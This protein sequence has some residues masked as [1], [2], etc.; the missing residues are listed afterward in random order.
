MSYLISHQEKKIDSC[1]KI[2]GSKSESNRLLILKA[3]YKNIFIKNISNSE[4]T[5]ILEKNLKNL[6]NKINVNHAGTAMRFLTA[7]L[8]IQA[9]KNFEIYGSKRMHERPIKVLVDALNSI[10]AD[11]KY[12]EKDGFPPLII[13]G[14]KIQKDSISIPSNVSSQYISALLLIS[15]MLKNGLTIKLKE[16]IASRPYIDMT[17]FF[18]RNIGVKLISKQYEIKVT[19]TESIKDFEYSVESDWSSLSYFY[20]IVSLAKNASLKIDKFHKNTVQGD[21]RLVQIYKNLGVRTSFKGSSVYLKKDVSLK[22]PDRII[23]DLVDCPDIAQTI[24]VSCFGL[25]ISCELNGLHTLKIKETDRL[26]ALKNELE[27]L[28]AS[29][30][31]TDKSLH[32]DKSEKIKT[33]IKIN[34]YDDHRMAMSF[35][36]LAIKIP[37]IIND[38]MVIKKSFPD[39]WTVLKA[40]GF[41][42]SKIN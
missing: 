1:F 41:K 5:S 22:I 36:A 12:L 6:K 27:K 13:R 15:P 19:H 18:L 34:T 35:A 11:I 10:G 30:Q 25:G 29:V 32:L 2:K 17:L 28:G 33:N 14:K 21:K 37:I 4:D 42:L 26:F 20:S 40:L 31:I 9:E 38:P 3:F 7:Y 24:A 39:F 23:L 8:S 16:A